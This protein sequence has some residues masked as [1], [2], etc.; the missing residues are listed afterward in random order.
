M[1]GSCKPIAAAVIACLWCE[2]SF[3]GT[4]ELTMDIFKNAQIGRLYMTREERDVLADSILRYW[5]NVNSRIPRLSPQ[6]KEWLDTEIN[7]DTD[8]MLR[9]I[10]KKESALD[11][12][13]RIAEQCVTAI[14]G[15][16]NNRPH[17]ATAPNLETFNWLEVARCYL[18]SQGIEYQL[19]K[20]GL[21]VGHADGSFYLIGNDTVLERVL[22]SVMLSSLA[23]AEGWPINEPKP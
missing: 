4:E 9:A 19:E 20:A 1:P 21:S 14:E 17:Y 16:I 6:E 12:A 23:D 8:R 11:V 13:G 18:K 3:A 22:D 10:D 5:N 15:L 2:A 7:G